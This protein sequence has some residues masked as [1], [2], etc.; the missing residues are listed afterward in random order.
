MVLSVPV[1]GTQF[2]YQGPH[3][4]THST[5]AWQSGEDPSQRTLGTASGR[6]VATYLVAASSALVQRIV[7][8]S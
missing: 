2:M 5:M 3:P 1:P 4:T 7:W 6:L 8:A